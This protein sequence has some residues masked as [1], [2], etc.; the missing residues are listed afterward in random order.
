MPDQPVTPFAK[1]AFL[2]DDVLDRN[3][4]RIDSALAAKAAA[5]ALPSS[6]LAPEATP[7]IGLAYTNSQTLNDTFWV[8]DQALA[9]TP[10]YYGR[11]AR[12]T[13][14]EV[15]NANILKAIYAL[16]PV[17]VPQAAPGIDF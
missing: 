4:R 16:A 15:L 13:G 17:A 11:K 3:F 5:A 10:V 8:L 2:G 9:T 6:P 14:D 1:F 7:T 12:F